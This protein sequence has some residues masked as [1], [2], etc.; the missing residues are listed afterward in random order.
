MVKGPDWGRGVSCHPEAATA[1]HCQTGLDDCQT[2]WD[3]CQT[4]SDDR[5]GAAAARGVLGQWAPGAELEGPGD[6]PAASVVWP[7][8]FA[9]EPAAFGAATCRQT[10]RPCRRWVETF[11]PTALPCHLLAATYRPLVGHH[12]P[13]HRDGR[14]LHPAGPRRARSRSQ[15]RRPVPGAGR[16]NASIAYQASRFRWKEAMRKRE[17]RTERLTSTF[18]AAVVCG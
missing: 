10:G 11:R 9:A 4:G 18:R 7:A 13:H 15:S 8:A 1:G 5:Q 2:G 14:H 3:D 6:E 16:W 17:G 12:H